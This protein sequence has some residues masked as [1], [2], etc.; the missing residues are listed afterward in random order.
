MLIQPHAAGL[1]ACNS[2]VHRGA[3]QRQHFSWRSKHNLTDCV[4]VEIIGEFDAF[5]VRLAFK[6][7]FNES[8]KWFPE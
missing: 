1:L 2:P 5:G 7:Y 4:A 8:I 6:K 3:S